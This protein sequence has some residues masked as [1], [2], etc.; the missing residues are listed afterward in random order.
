MTQQQ[1]QLDDK[2]PQPDERRL[3]HSNDV[4]PAK[5]AGASQKATRTKLQ[6]EVLTILNRFGPLTDDK[7]SEYFTEYDKGTVRKRRSEL[8]QMGLV[9]EAGVGVS[10]RGKPMTKWEAI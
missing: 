2:R 10:D 3:S 9:Q 5:Q 6:Q 8:F 7:L 1:F 4:A